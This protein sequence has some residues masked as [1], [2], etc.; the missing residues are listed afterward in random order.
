MASSASESMPSNIF[1]M[2]AAKRDVGEGGADEHA[3][4]QRESHRHAEIAEGQEA[5]PS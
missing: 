4:H 2:I 5:A 1:W 3:G